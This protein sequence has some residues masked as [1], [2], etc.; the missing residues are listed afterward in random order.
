MQVVTFPTRIPDYDSHTPTVLDLFLSSDSSFR[1]A[2]VS[3]HQKILI[4]KI[5]SRFPLTFLQAQK[6]MLLFSAQL[7]SIPM[8]IWTVLII[9]LEMFYRRISLN[10]VLLLLQLNFVS[11]SRLALM[12]ISLNVNIKSRLINFHGFSC[13]CCNHSSQKSL[14]SSV[15]TE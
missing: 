15:P 8:L 11:G 5:L 14:L 1:S 2:V 3:V 4:I 12:Y 9:I 13:L 6:R 10:L 7:R